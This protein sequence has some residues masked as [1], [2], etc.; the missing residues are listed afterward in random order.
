MDSLRLAKVA[1]IHPESNSV[2]IVF[3]GGGGQVPGVQVMSPMA[4]TNTGLTGLAK[5]AMPASGNK[6]DLPDTNTRDVLAVVGFFSN[7]PIVLG[8]LFP[9]VCQMLFE[10]IE[11]SVDRHPSDV[12]MTTDKDGN[13]ELYH[14]SGTYVRIGT[15]AAHEDLTGKDLDGLWKIERNT[16]KAVHVQ[17]TVKNAGVQK[18]SLHL[19]PSGNINLSHV[20]NL[21]SAT[22]GTADITV[23]G[24]AAVHA[25]QIT[26]DTP[27][28]ICTGA[29]HV[30]TGVVVTAGGVAVTA[31]GVHSAAGGITSGSVGLE[32][33][34]HSNPEGGNT[35]AA[36]G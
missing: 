17:L 34:V 12:Y 10:D 25:P 6:Y 3:I 5:P 20:G 36:T 11:R 30:A 9:Q 28:T 27:L 33:H 24:N 14:P 16:D 4:S 7:Q 18:A 2:D 13:T 23:T 35:G 21:V 8:F 32:S 1:D 29:L 31:G 22:G 15:A 26:L 19:D